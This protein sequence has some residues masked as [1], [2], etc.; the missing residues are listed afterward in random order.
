MKTR[1]M[2]PKRTSELDARLGRLKAESEHKRK[3]GLGVG[4]SL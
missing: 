4:V 1:D 3:K 2:E